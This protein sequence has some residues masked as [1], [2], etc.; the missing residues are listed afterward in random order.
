MTPCE[1]SIVV[2]F[3]SPFQPAP[4]EQISACGSGSHENGKWFIEDEEEEEKGVATLFS[5]LCSKAAD[6]RCHRPDGTKDEPRKEKPYKENT[7]CRLFNGRKVNTYI[8]QAQPP[9]DTKG[10]DS[11]GSAAERMI[12]ISRWFSNGSIQSNLKASLETRRQ[13]KTKHVR[14]AICLKKRPN[15]SPFY[16]QRFFHRPLIG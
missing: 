11:G 9:D 15:V 2:G 14:L 5:P 1:I 16:L 3:G 10:G 8:S 4:V 6:T 7:R 12:I 13:S